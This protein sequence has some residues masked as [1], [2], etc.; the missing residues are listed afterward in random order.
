CSLAAP[1]NKNAGRIGL[2][3]CRRKIFHFQYAG[4][5]IHKVRV[6]RGRIGT[7][8]KIF[9]RAA[10]DAHLRSPGRFCLRKLVTVQEWQ[11]RVRHL[12]R[13]TDFVEVT[14]F[15]AQLSSNSPVRTSPLRT[16]RVISTPPGVLVECARVKA[17]GCAL[18]P[19]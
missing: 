5:R 7:A 16:W 2:N 8:P 6:Q 17:D 9:T 15:S 19:N 14:G 4:K 11:S 10:D 13:G 18:S 3:F 12:W 1:A